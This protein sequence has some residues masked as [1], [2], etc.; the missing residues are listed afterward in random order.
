MLE[1]E[2]GFTREMLEVE[3]GFFKELLHAELRFI[4]AVA[5]SVKIYQ[6]VVIKLSYDSSKSC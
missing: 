6:R 2:L 5:S 3:L 1:V 4:I